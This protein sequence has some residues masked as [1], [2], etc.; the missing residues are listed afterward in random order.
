MTLLR[1]C[2]AN[3]Q[4]Q[5]LKGLKSSEWAGHPISIP[6]LITLAL[7]VSTKNF[8][9]YCTVCP[10][11]YSF[12]FAGEQN[13]GYTTLL[14]RSR[15]QA[16]LTVTCPIFINK[17]RMLYWS[18]AIDN[19]NKHHTLF[20]IRIISFYN[21]MVIFIMPN[22]VILFLWLLN[23]SSVQITL[24]THVSEPVYSRCQWQN[25]IICCL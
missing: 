11:E 12:Q 22:S 18:F 25:W 23:F 13:V 24:I 16:P 10:D 9:F 4:K 15:L 5:K 14:R 8:R 19:G 6:R 1:H 2:W 21:F 7:N 20:I 3:A 17:Y